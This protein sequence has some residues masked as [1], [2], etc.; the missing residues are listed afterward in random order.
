M[1]FVEAQDFCEEHGGEISH[2][3]ENQNTALVG[4]NTG[5]VVDKLLI[6][7]IWCAWVRNDNDKWQDDQ[8]NS[9]AP[10]DLTGD[11]L[12]GWMGYNLTSRHITR[13]TNDIPHT[14]VC[15]GK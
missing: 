5:W 10:S 4:V 15:Y 8:G 14:V 9:I 12:N 13:E 2:C 11:I 6:T 7:G 1:P 3:S